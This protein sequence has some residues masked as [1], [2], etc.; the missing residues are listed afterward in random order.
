MSYRQSSTGLSQMTDAVQRRE[1]RRTASFHDAAARVLYGERF[2]AIAI[3]AVA[4]GVAQAHSRR[5]TPTAH[6]LPAIL[7]NGWHD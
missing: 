5:V 6:E 4:A 1:P 7:R 2:S 3:P